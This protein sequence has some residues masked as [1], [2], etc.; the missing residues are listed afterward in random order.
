MVLGETNLRHW[1]QVMMTGIGS[2]FFEEWLG[3]L[4]IQVK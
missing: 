1:T 3:V 2:V 4:F